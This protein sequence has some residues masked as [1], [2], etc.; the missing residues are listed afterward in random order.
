VTLNTTGYPRSFDWKN[1]QQMI[2][3]K[4]NV[5]SDAG[6]SGDQTLSTLINTAFGAASSGARLWKDKF[7]GGLF[8]SMKYIYAVEVTAPTYAVADEVGTSLIAAATAT[9]GGGS[10]PGNAVTTQ[11]QPVTDIVFSSTTLGD[12]KAGILYFWFLK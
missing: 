11:M 9:T 1:N 5:V 3:Y 8:Y 6:A 12:T 2:V 10:L 4:V 7:A